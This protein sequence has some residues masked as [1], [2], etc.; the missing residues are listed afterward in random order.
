MLEKDLKKFDL[1]KPYAKGKIN[2]SESKIKTVI[3]DQGF[4]SSIK[5]QLEKGKG[6]MIYISSTKENEGTYEIYV[7]K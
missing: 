4:S 6:L 5:E 7:P 3:F 2:I 1:E